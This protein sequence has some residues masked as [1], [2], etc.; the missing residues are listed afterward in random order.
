[1]YISYPCTYIY[2]YTCIHINI[3][4]IFLTVN[5]IYIKLLAMVQFGVNGLTYVGVRVSGDS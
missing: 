1:M 3:Y 5:Y 4:I 2:S